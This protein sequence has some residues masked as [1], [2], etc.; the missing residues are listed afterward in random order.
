MERTRHIIIG[1][2]GHVD[3]GKTTL[4]HALTGTNPD[5]LAEEQARGMTI[6]LGFAFLELPGNPPLFAGMVD[7]PGHEKFVKNMLAGAG[8]VDVALVI[9]AADEG[10]MPQTREHLDILTIL[11]VSVGVVALTKCDLADPELADIVEEATREE[12]ATTSLKDTPIIRV[13]AITGEGLATLKE[14]LYTAAERV[15]PRDERTPF[16]LPIDRVFSLAGVGTV[17]TG[18]LVA[19]TLNIGDAIAIQPQDQLSKARTLQT[20]HR[21][22]DS[23]V[24]GMRVA[25]NLPG[26]EVADIERG[27]VL[28]P[29]GFVDATSLFDASVSLL[30]NA[31]RPLRHCERVRVHLGTGEVL[32]RIL[33]LKG[34]EIL[35][36]SSNIALQIQCEAPVAPLIGE[37]FVLRTYS[38]AVAI[39]GGVILETHPTHRYRR[40][41]ALAETLF[42]ARGSGKMIE[43]I[44][45]ALAARPADFTSAEI[46]TVA[47]VTE[48]VAEVELEALAAQ[49]RANVLMDGRYIADTTAKRLRDTANRVLTQY[50][51]QNPFKKAMPRDGLRVP[52]Q[53]AAEYH[54]FNSLIS[55]LITE[56][57]IVAEGNGVRLPEHTVEIPEGWKYA[58]SHILS[59]YASAGFSPP[60]P[61]NFQANYPKDVNVRTILTIHVEN[62]DLVT[63]ADDLYLHHIPYGTARQAVKELAGSPGGITVGNLRDKLG[64][65]RKIILPLLEHFDALRLT[66][67][68]GDMRILME[69][70]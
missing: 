23:A 3:H 49:Q 69:N 30:P 54:D 46:G 20:A 21:K 40:G 19:G 52:L 5:R 41:D 51:R 32:G 55:F 16:R 53:K 15:P 59:V 42:Q 65:S 56:G 50:H 10:P 60:S 61:G 8:G 27:A 26:I 64:S 47:G 43:S 33:L 28:Y 37:R 38:P 14:A 11:G 58:A 57:V 12:L 22:V 48:T 67:R 31:K 4:V 66:R 9:V 13:S 39:G 24:A 17:V 36:G 63:I 29:V 25:V 35:P 70:G 62:G 6:D 45:A 18:T 34:S 44:Y 68:V 7:V 1:T 2:A